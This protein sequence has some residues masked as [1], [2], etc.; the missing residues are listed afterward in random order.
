MPQADSSGKRGMGT[1]LGRGRRGSQA[2]SH[3]PRSQPFWTAAPL[4]AFV[5]GVTQVVTARVKGAALLLH[6]IPSW[7]KPS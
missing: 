3:V 4:G 7:G 6:R 1:G 5:H 2:V